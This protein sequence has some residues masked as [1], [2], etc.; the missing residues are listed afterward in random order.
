MLKLPETPEIP[1]ETIRSTST[2]HELDKALRAQGWDDTLSQKVINSPTLAELLVDI[3]RNSE[4][5]ERL[6]EI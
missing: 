3:V 2:N 1:P 4:E 6:K 5:L